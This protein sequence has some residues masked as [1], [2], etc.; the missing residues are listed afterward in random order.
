MGST[1]ISFR[2]YSSRANR[3]KT[4][5]SLGPCIVAIVAHC[6]RMP[7]FGFLVFLWRAHRHW[8]DIRWKYFDL[9]ICSW[10]RKSMSNRCLCVYSV[11]L[12]DSPSNQFKQPDQ[13]NDRPIKE[14]TTMPRE[15]MENPK[16]P[17]PTRNAACAHRN[18]CI[19]A[20][21]TH[22]NRVKQLALSDPP[23]KRISV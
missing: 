19:A 15:Y 7:S 4:T 16:L 3:K 9:L 17:K 22:W 20:Y 10:L 6:W 21:I 11:H 14:G 12:F 8:I 5:H 13:K 18:A 2:F 1:F 23:P